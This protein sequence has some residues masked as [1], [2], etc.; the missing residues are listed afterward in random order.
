MIQKYDLEALLLIKVWS[1]VIV[2]ILCMGK[3]IVAQV[4]TKS[5]RF[6]TYG[7]RGIKTGPLHRLQALVSRYMQPYKVCDH[8]HIANPWLQFLF[9][10]ITFVSLHELTKPTYLIRLTKYCTLVCSHSTIY[11]EA[12]SCGAMRMCKTCRYSVRLSCCTVFCGF[13]GCYQRCWIIHS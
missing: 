2:D 1:I 12:R 11:N 6:A 4:I 7:A 8:S 5:K 13:G 3:L 9:Y 10:K